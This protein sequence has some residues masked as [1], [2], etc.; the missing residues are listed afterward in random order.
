MRSAPCAGTTNGL[1]TR[2]TTKSQPESARTA[3]KVPSSRTRF[4]CEEEGEGEEGEEE[5]FLM[6]TGDLPFLTVCFVDLGD[7]M[8]LDVEV[9]VF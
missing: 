5:V 8:G 4:L 6:V 3:I 2:A 9:G 1:R 7:L